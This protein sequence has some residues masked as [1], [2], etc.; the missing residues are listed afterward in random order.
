[1]KEMKTW[2]LA[3]ILMSCLAG[4]PA[5]LA[6]ESA[7][8]SAPGAFAALG[9]WLE[10]LVAALV[11]EDP[12]AVQPPAAQGDAPNGDHSEIQAYIIPGG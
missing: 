12:L 1:M 2:L 9:D 10:T 5:V 7:A 8:G 4:A 11:G 3:L 6:A